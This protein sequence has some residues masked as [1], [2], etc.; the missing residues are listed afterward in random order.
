M[1]SA[2]SKL[3]YGPSGPR[4]TWVKA[5]SSELS[6]AS[7]TSAAMIIGSGKR[8]ISSGTNSR[9]STIAT[10]TARSSAVSAAIRFTPRHPTH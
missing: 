8:G 6:T 3:W 7:R 2:L 9:A 5:S 4:S 1:S 10:T